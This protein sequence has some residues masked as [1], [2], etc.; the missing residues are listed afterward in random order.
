M[1]T[2]ICLFALTALT[3]I[4]CDKKEEGG[5]IISENRSLSEF[6]EIDVVGHMEVEIDPELTADLVITAPQNLMPFIETEVSG[7]QLIIRE[8]DND[9][10]PSRIMIRIREQEIS[11]IELSG[12]GTVRGDSIFSETIALRLTGSGMID[13][14]VNCT[15]LHTQITGSGNIDVVGSGNKVYSRIEGSGRISTETIESTWADARI[16][17]SGYIET[18]ASDSLKALLSGSGVIRCWG[19]PYHVISDANGSGSIIY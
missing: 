16:D 7:D 19:K 9:I 15:S 3:I 10:E 2:R 14:S 18:Y 1:K 4:G 11:E 5:P 13:L 12:S 17:G 6:E 8:R